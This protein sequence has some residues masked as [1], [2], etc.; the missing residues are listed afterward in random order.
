MRISK[1]SLSGTEFAPRRKTFGKYCYKDTCALRIARTVTRVANFV[2]DRRSVGCKHRPCSLTKVKYFDLV[3]F[4]TTT[5]TSLKNRELAKVHILELQAT[6]QRTTNT[7]WVCRWTCR[8]DSEH[9][10]TWR[11]QS[12]VVLRYCVAWLAFLQIRRPVYF[13]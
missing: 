11:R 10:R 3:V 12:S 7:E 4:Y 6:G 1:G 9:G 8:A 13:S 5:Q 2:T